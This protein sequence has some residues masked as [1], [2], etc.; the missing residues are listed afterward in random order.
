MSPETIVP[1][2]KSYLKSTETKWARMRF[3]LLALLTFNL[4]L[5]IV[6]S[7]GLDIE[8]PTPPA[9]P[10]WVQKSLP[11]EWPERGIDAHESGGI[12]LE[13]E[14][15]PEDNIIAYLIYR[16]EY[17]DEIESLGGYE[18]IHRLVMVSNNALEYVD[19]GLKMGIKYFYKLKAD[20]L[21]DNRS[22]YSDSSM[23]YL[24]PAISDKRMAPNGV[25]DS[26]SP[27]RL[28]NW[29]YAS[30]IDIE[31]YCLTILSQ[32]DD[33]IIR[34]ILNPGNY[35]SGSESW[36][37][38]DSI[39]LQLNQIYKWRIDTGGKYL[40]DLETAGSESRWATFQYVGD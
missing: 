17:F 8:D 40:N 14:P 11:E 6:Q 28:L 29:S 18:R 13:W 4:S 38:P 9:P 12:F 2:I 1:S 33:F 24:L 25:S 31:D 5:I 26:L 10:V 32:N 21:S 22:S 16:A 36:Q 3:W 15:N 35:I 37:I 27:A 20:D 19:T 30:Q 34:V 39:D 7:C 23:F